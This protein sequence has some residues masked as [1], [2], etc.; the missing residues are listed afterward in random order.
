MS[1]L[2]QCPFCGG[3][4]LD[5]D[6]IKVP[7]GFW[8]VLCR[9]CEADGPRGETPKEATAAWNTRVLFVDGE[10]PDDGDES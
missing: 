7:R 6:C 8:Y 10:A 1:K 9:P 4:D 5:I 3:D 2:K